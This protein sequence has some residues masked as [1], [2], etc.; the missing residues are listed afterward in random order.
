M[1]NIKLMNHCNVEKFIELGFIE[2]TDGTGSPWGIDWNYRN[3]NYHIY[4]DCTFEVKLARLDVNADFI[5]VIVDDLHDL[6]TLIAF[7][8]P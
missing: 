5:G 7:I 6:E 1:T 3:E 4:I 8:Q 2:E